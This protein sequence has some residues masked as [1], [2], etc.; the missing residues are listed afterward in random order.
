MI[1]RIAYDIRFF[2]VILGLVLAGFSLAFWLISYPGG[3]QV[4]D[5]DDSMF[6]NVN[7]SLLNTFYLML[8]MFNPDMS[9]TVSQELGYVLVILFSLFIIILMLNLLIAL[10]NDSYGKIQK[11]YIAQWRYEQTRVILDEVDQFYVD[12]TI[13]SYIHVLQSIDSIEK[14]NVTEKN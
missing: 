4:G 9:S 11:N 14:E 13:P 8:G 6:D 1:I 7:K 12:T 10:M 5:N 3:G 2:I